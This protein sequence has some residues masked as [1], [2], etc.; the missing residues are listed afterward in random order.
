MPIKSPFVRAHHI[1]SHI[2]N[3]VWPVGCIL[4]LS[5]VISGRPSYEQAAFYCFILS[6]LTTP[7]VYLSG[8]MDW[9]NRF[10]GRVSRIFNH[11]IAFG[12]IFMSVSAI[13]LI[14]RLLD[15]ALPETG[16]PFD[17]YVTLALANLGLVGY[18]G[19]LGGKFL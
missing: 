11:K 8:V 17:I 13:M 7:I 4:L 1:F 2:T 15:P 9:K 19:L 18:L 5:H 6:T 16:T 10:E 12:I 14:W 3:G